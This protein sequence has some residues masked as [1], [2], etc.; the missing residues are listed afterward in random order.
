MIDRKYHRIVFSFFMALIMSCV[1]SCT[2]SFVN[3]GPVSNFLS[4]WMSAWYFG[5]LIAF[6]SVFLVSPLV[7]KL[8]AL[9]LKEEKSEG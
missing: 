4:I 3:V 6:P 1:M 7:H 9:V 8:T 5:F 2:I